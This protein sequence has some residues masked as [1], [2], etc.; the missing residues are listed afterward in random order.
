MIC[1]FVL[2]HNSVTFLLHKAVGLTDQN[3]LMVSLELVSKVTTLVLL[4][5]QSNTAEVG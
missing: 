3:I 5:N 1:V 2:E 4:Y